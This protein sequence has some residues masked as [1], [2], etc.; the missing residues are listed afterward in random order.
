MSFSWRKP[1]R[2]RPLARHIVCAVPLRDVEEED[3]GLRRVP[4]PEESEA[5]GRVRGVE[6]ERMEAAED[7]RLVVGVGR[8]G[9][10][11]AEGTVLIVPGLGLRSRLL[12]VER[13]PSAPTGRVLV[14]L[15]VSAKCAVTAVPSVG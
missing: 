13:V 11:R 15:E 1:P 10:G 8:V 12:V 5:A 7:E 2:L 3:P 14:V 6:V 4:H 9:A